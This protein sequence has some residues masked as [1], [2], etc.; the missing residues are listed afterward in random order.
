MKHLIIP[1]RHTGIYSNKIYYCIGIANWQ[2]NFYEVC[3]HLAIKD[4]Y[5]CVALR[6]E[7]AADKTKAGPCC[8]KTDIQ[9]TGQYRKKDDEF[10]RFTCTRGRK[11]VTFFE[12]KIWSSTK[13]VPPKVC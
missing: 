1:A 2:W 9:I 3:L 7:F 11:L 4:F 6:A 8:P 10:K 5:I 12:G 13:L